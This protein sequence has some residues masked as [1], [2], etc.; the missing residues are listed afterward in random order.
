MLNQFVNIINS[1]DISDIDIVGDS[2]FIKNYTITDLPFLNELDTQQCI[3]SFNRNGK[4]VV[5]SDLKINDIIDTELSLLRLT[6]I[7]YYENFDTFI[8][9]YKYSI[10]TNQYYIREFKCFCSESNPNIVAYQNIVV[11]IDSIKQNA[12]HCYNETDIEYSVVF[13][14]DK[15]L[16]LPF[17]YDVTDVQKITTTDNEKLKSISLAFENND[18]DNKKLI[19]I[20]ELI[21]FLSS[22]NES[23]RFK[24]LLSHIAEYADRASNA[25][26]YYIR[27]FSYNK[28]KTELDNA[29]LD[30]SK[31]I[32]SVINDAQTKLI[33]IPTAFLLATAS[34]DFTKIVSGK[35]IGIIVGLFIFAWLIELFIKNQASALV[36]I[37][38]NI[39]VYKKTFKSMNDIVKE[40][41]EIVDT[42]WEKQ[43]ER[44]TIIRWIV[45][46]VPIAILIVSIIFLF[47]QKPIINTIAE[48]YNQIRQK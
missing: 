26:Q 44:I 39:D 12:K 24:F 3:N 14:E 40:S 25:Y 35:S 32:Q 17:I 5:Y 48:W 6:T 7:G 19:Y 15:A 43:I 41:F 38:Q 30:Y 8:R 21:D 31:K 34:M 33:A 29:A 9:K 22:E 2:I 18:S 20:N 4:I 42:E 28:L 37:K 27:N 36:F 46:I 23:E 11:L 1:V 47:T 13:R 10:P 45:W 16:F